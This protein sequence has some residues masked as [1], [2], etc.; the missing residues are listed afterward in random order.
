[1]TDIDPTPLQRQ[2]IEA[3]LD[4]RVNLTGYAGCGKSTAAALRVRYILEHDTKWPEVMIFTPGRAYSTAYD[5]LISADGIR[6]TVTSCNSF[7]QRCLKLFWPIISDK[8]GTGHPNEYPMFLTIETAQIIM[9][10]DPRPHGRRLLLRSGILQKPHLQSSPRRHAQMR[11]G[12]DSLR[13]I[14]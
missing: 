1:M 10:A 4:A 8:A 9:E 7:M 5:D 6:P 13:E 12:G 2:I 11:R 14:R 3:P